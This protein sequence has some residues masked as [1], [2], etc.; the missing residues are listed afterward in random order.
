MCKYVGDPLIKTVESIYFRDLV[1]K[2][3]MPPEPSGCLF[4]FHLDKTHFLYFV[5]L[6][7]E[8]SVVSKPL[9]RVS[10]DGFQAYTFQQECRDI[11]LGISPHSLQTLGLNVSLPSPFLGVLWLLFQAGGDSL[12]VPRFAEWNA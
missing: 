12:E 1:S 10:L 6:G 7:E 4:F 8:C 5:N 2:N 9:W 11:S 3:W